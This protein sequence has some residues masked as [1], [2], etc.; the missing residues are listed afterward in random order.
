M[1]FLFIIPSEVCY[2]FDL[3]IFNWRMIVLQYWFDF[4]HTSVWI[5]HRCTYVPSLLKLPPFPTSLGCY[6]APVWVPWVMN[7]LITYFC[8]SLCPYQSDLVT[9]AAVS[10]THLQPAQYNFLNARERDWV[11]ASKC[12]GITWACVVHCFCRILPSRIKMEPWLWWL[13]SLFQAPA[14]PSS[15]GVSFSLP[16]TGGFMLPPLDSLQKGEL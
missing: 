9:P 8:P 4:C 14:W 2:F 12:P 16:Q 5:S 15:G 3:F 7:Y 11:S 13:W 6:R 1:I 10:H